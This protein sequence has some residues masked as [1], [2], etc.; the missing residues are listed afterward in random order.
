M[1]KKKPS[2]VNEYFCYTCGD[3]IE[4]PKIGYA[5]PPVVAEIDRLRYII[6]E[7]SELLM[8]YG[9]GGTITSDEQDVID[10]IQKEA[11]RG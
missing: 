10:M 3:I 9:D 4:I 2:M 8:S 6:K 7:A 1:V 11:R 5:S